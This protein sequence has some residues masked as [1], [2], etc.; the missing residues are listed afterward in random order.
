MGPPVPL[1]CDNPLLMPVRD[2]SALWEALTNVINDYFRIE[3]EEPVRMVG[4]TLT[5]GRIDTFPETGS[6]VLEPWRHD[7]ADRYE[8]V[9]STLQSIRRQAH[10]R[11]I[12]SEGGF[13]VD[14]TVFKELEDVKR[15]AHV[16]AGAATFRT[17]GSLT[18]VV[19]PIG[20]Q[21]VNK[22]WI[23]LGRDRALEQRI[24][25]HLQETLGVQGLS[26]IPP[27]VPASPP[28]GPSCQPTPAKGQPSGP[29]APPRCASGP[30]KL[31]APSGPRTA[32]R[33]GVS[34]ASSGDYRRTDWQVEDLG[35]FEEPELRAG[36]WRARWG[37]EFHRLLDCGIEDYRRFYSPPEL[38][39]L[40]GGIGLA[41]VFANA[42]IGD[43]TIDE[44]FQQ[45]H[46]EH[47]ATHNARKFA[48]VVKEFGNGRH[49][50]PF[51][52]VCSGAGQA[53][54]SSPTAR[55]IGEWGD[56]SL[57]SF[58]VG[59]PVILALQYGLGASRPEDHT[60]GSRWVP[61]F[62]ENSASGHAF[63]GGINFINAAMMTDNVPLKSA[64]YVASIVPGWSRIIQDKHYISQV[65][66]GWWVAYL[67]ASA[68][69]W[70][71]RGTSDWQI[72][73]VVSDDGMAVQFL[74]AW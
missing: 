13:L 20:E 40:A 25:A 61:F 31:S 71:E 23:R 64:L 66:L 10:V 14:V 5:E 38:F 9:E 33:P 72:T 30:D 70:N 4:D 35:S 65:V 59:G 7:S 1:Y 28:N 46:H 26:P 53:W 27:A 12:P 39:A 19:S 15:P 17:E 48:Y 67:S 41:A 32:Y 24:L 73:P 58:F 36:G 22:G 42:D 18:R 56:R 74:R 62:A 47:V 69:D 11:V 55:T 6:T 60:N 44:N 57:R 16:S 8:K 63:I 34:E 2:S 21:E 29:A 37:E 68:V 54:E 43:K 49:F 3:S 50:L 52:A 51:Y 45:W